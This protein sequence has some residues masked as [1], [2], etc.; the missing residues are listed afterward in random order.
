MRDSRSIDLALS[1]GGIRAMAFH[2]GVLRRLAEKGEMEKV[3]R[4]S[5]VSGG[6]LITGMIVTEAGMSWPESDRFLR[7]IYPAL[8]EKLCSRSLMK[9]MILSLL[10]PSHMRFILNRANLMAYH[11]AKKWGITARLSDL[12]PCP[13][14]SF[15]GTTAENGRR[16]RFNRDNMGDYDSGYTHCGKLP[17]ATAMAVSAAFPGGIGPLKLY[18]ASFVWTKP[19]DWKQPHKQATITPEFDTLNLYDGGVYDNLGLEPFFNVKTNKPKGKSGY[20]LVSDAGSPFTKGFSMFALNPLRL[21]RIMDVMQEQCRSLRVRGLWGYLEENPEKGAYIWINA[22]LEKP[23]LAKLRAFAAGFPTTLRKLSEKEFD[24]LAEY[25]FLVAG[26]CMES[27]GFCAERDPAVQ[28][29]VTGFAL[30]EEAMEQSGS[31]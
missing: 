14:F 15:E 11:L 20:L 29:V 28:E 21:K 16:F 10:R 8:R 17:L 9:G 13:E 1:G 27:D 18:T 31:M 5:S 23:E 12:P 24:D 4:V 25:G 22:D 2:M 3:R 19:E 30:P 6:S 7:D 26:S